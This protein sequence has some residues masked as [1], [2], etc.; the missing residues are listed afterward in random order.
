MEAA[1]KPIAWLFALLLAVYSIVLGVIELR[2]SQDFVR[3]F[4]TDIEGEVLFHAVNTTLSAGLLGGAALLLAFASLSGGETV[5]ARARS[6]LLSQS[7]M[8]G[9]LAL[10][11]RFQLH[12]R[13]GY[14]LGVA[15][16]YVM[17]VWAATELALL[18]LFCRPQF[19]TV[20]MAALFVAGTGCFGLMLVFD[21]LVPHDMVLRLSIEDLAK[22]WGAALFFAFA[23]VAAQFHLDAASRGHRAASLASVEPGLDAG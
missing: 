21:A 2:T 16:H 20:R 13:I 23:W 5:G 11:D 6:F 10:D 22:A 8:F 3:H 17:L 18:A 1:L 15:D 12:E 7:A 14:R 4:F 9:L 19:V